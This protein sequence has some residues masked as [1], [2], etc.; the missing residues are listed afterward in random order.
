MEI[1]FKHVLVADDCE[2]TRTRLKHELSALGYFVESATDGAEA[3]KLLE[4]KPFD[5]L[6]TD[7]EMP[8]IDG[9]TLCRCVRAAPPEQYVYIIMMTAHANSV[10]VATGMNAGADDF[11]VKPINPRELAARML[12]GSRVLALDRNLTTLATHDPLTGALNRRTYISGIAS[13]LELSRRRGMPL[14]CILLDIDDFS[15]LNDDF[16]HI[17]GDQ[18]LVRV[19][20]VLKRRFRSSDFVFRYGGEEFTVVLSGTDESGAQLCA[21]R[22]RQEI[23][24]LQI[25]GLE[26]RQ[27]TVSCGVA[28]ANSVGITP[29]ELTDRAD[30][31]LRLA[32]KLGCNQTVRYSQCEAHGLNQVKLVLPD[33]YTS[34][35]V[36]AKVPTVS[37]GDC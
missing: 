7:W 12:S 13:Q 36:A 28:E 5:F 22:C 2:V 19:A 23:G 33:D 29:M 17:V 11:I 3:L 34:K 31:A 37:F 32:K 1:Q 18:I 20:E 35:P 9:E 27:I 15:A 21:E 26:D 25:Q 16:G 8:N 30:L 4:T 10:D 24:E 14:S 6:L